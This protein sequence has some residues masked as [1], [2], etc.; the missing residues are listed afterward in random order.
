MQIKSTKGGT[1][2]NMYVKSEA[3]SHTVYSER[4]EKSRNATK[5]P[6]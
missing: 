3:I 5:L 4:L 6:L 1:F 2:M